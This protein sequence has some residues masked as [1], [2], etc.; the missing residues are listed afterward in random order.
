M[1]RA[2]PHPDN[3]QKGLSLEDLTALYEQRYRPLV[4]IL[5]QQVGRW[6][7][8]EDLAQRTFVEALLSRG[9]FRPGTSAAKWLGGIAAHTVRDWMAKE[10]GRR[11][12][13]R[14]E[15]LDALL[16]NPDLGFDVASSTNVEDEVTNADA[17]E[18]LLRQLPPR[19]A[20]ALRLL[21]GEDYT[22]AKAAA[23]MNSTPDTIRALRRRGENALREQLGTD[24]QRPMNTDDHGSAEPA[25]RS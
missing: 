22:P 7:D 21:Y 3:D 17:F 13:A 2:T 12:I 6:E 23:T 19:R 4:R 20:E 14:M 9:T 25:D 5:C 15:S 10:Q 24:P 11:A 18:E 8:A 1:P 16:D